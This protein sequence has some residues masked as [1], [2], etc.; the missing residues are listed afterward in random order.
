MYKKAGK[1]L[2]RKG[3]GLS[4]RAKPVKVRKKT[5][6]RP[7]AKVPHKGKESSPA[8]RGADL[9]NLAKPKVRSKSKRPTDTR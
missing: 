2:A 5:K 6:R 8:T 1:S 4:W 3:T 7:K 9:Y